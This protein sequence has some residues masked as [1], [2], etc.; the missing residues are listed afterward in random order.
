MPTTPVV[1][2]PL[3]THPTDWSPENLKPTLNLVL[4]GCIVP[5]VAGSAR[6][7]Y[8]HLVVLD[9]F[10][11]EPTRLQ[12][13]DYLTEPGWYYADPPASKWSRSTS[14]ADEKPET[15]GLHSS[16]LQQFAAQDLPAKL[17]V[18]TR[19]CMLYPDM[20]IAH[21]P[22]KYIQMGLANARDS[23]EG[24]EVCV[25][26]G[27]D[28]KS[29]SQQQPQGQQ[30]RQHEEQPHNQHWGHQQHPQQQQVPEQQE[31]QQHRQHQQQP[32]GSQSA[33]Q[34]P[35]QATAQQHH[36]QHRET[37]MQQAAGDCSFVLANAAVY[38]DTFTWHVDA[39]PM[40]FAVSSP[41]VQ[42]YGLYCNR[43]PDMPLFATLL[44]YL[45]ADWP[46]DYNAE[47]L[48]LDSM[49]DTG[50]FVRPKRYRAVLMDQDIVHRLSTPSASAGR[51]R[52]SLVWKVVMWPKQQGAACS[53]A[54]PE[55]GRRTYFGSA[56][57]VEQAAKAAAAGLVGH[58]RSAVSQKE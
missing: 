19:L 55:W 16:I 9:N 7:D 3:R 8:S 44:L 13:L 27:Y 57:H 15:W 54:R 34:A 56:A 53:I 33:E 31:H 43:E 29:P 2:T 14:D 39:D 25:A 35:Q 58:K 40:S 21:M 41:W 46:L 5:T 10:I 20:I 49:T 42:Q 11:D 22:T 28:A 38:G 30:Y 50:I 24:E 1:C 45:D 52:Y 4:D 37:A 17:E 48:F 18:Q 6:V 36:Q 47:T 32:Q 12:L 26:H 23:A 51:P